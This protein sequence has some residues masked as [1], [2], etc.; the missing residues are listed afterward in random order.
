[1]SEQHPSAAE[2]APVLS[3]ATV[4]GFEFTDARDGSMAA[5]Q[6][7]PQLLLD[8]ELRRRPRAPR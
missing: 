2:L 6:R 4:V 8:P 7:H 5:L 3:G 1:M